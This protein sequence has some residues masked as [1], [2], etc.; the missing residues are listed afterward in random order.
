MFRAEIFCW[1]L[2]AH[3][4]LGIKFGIKQKTGGAMVVVATV[5]YSQIFG[6]MQVFSHD[7]QGAVKFF[8]VQFIASA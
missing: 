2:Q 4:H 3:F 8:L 5:K 6:D 1:L 7:R